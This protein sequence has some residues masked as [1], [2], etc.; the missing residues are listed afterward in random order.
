MV[1][2]HFLFNKENYPMVNHIDKNKQNNHIS[3]LEWCDSFSNM[4]H[5]YRTY[6]VPRG[7]SL[8]RSN[9]WQATIVYENNN[10]YLGR[11]K[12]LEEA[13]SIWYDKYIELRGAKPW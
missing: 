2:D 8:T 5:S 4:E 11:Y 1:A 12:T 7:V 10:I 13:R 6:G 9:T 3:N